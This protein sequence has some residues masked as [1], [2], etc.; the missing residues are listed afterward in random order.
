MLIRFDRFLHGR[1]F[2][3]LVRL[4]QRHLHVNRYHILFVSEIL[5]DV[6]F[7][8]TI[9]LGSLYRFATTHDPFFVAM[10]L[11]GLWVVS[12]WYAYGS[13]TRVFEA[14]RETSA[15]FEERGFAKPPVELIRLAVRRRAD[16]PFWNVVNVTMISVGI[17][18]PFFGLHTDWLNVAF[19][20]SFANY[21]FNAHLWDVDDLD[22]RDR[23]YFLRT[24]MQT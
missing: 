22:P 4:I 10:F 8:T 24:Q 20:L 6:L 12:S 3:P 9:V 17:F 14:M 13:S 2:N 1:V 11:F 19:H 21:L 5:Q 18:L 15:R 7:V 23:E 16:R